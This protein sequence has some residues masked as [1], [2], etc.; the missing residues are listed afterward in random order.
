M[1]QGHVF[2]I[3]N[4]ESQV[5]DSNDNHHA[6]S[7]AAVVGVIVVIALLSLFF[8]IYGLFYESIRSCINGTPRDSENIDASM[9]H[10]SSTPLVNGERHKSSTPVRD[11]E[12]NEPQILE[13]RPPSREPRSPSPRLASPAPPVAIAPPDATH[14]QAIMEPPHLTDVV[15]PNMEADGTATVHPEVLGAS[16]VSQSD[17]NEFGEFASSSTEGPPMP[18]CAK[19]VVY[20][21]T[22]QTEHNHETP[23]VDISGNEGE[24]HIYSGQKETYVAALATETVSVPIS[25]PVQPETTV[26][27]SAVSSCESVTAVTSETDSTKDTQDLVAPKQ[28]DVE[29]DSAGSLP[30]AS[31]EV[32]AEINAIEN[33]APKSE[34]PSAVSGTDTVSTPLHGDASITPASS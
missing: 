19:E 25:V 26:D 1:P 31:P 11:I 6:N 24:G 14:A 29:A 4:G 16:S 34:D 28:I 7:V 15:A 13:N 2:R 20:E 30:S 23:P 32:V 27:A 17:D 33:E 9:S 12:A 5:D 8:S 10:H 18:E 22:P 21:I 3:L